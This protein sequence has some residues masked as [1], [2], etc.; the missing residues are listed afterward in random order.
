MRYRALIF[1]F[2]GDAIGLF[3][4]CKQGLKKDGLIIVKE[5]I[6]SKE[7]EFVVDKVCLH[8]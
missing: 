2:T 6:C 3:N 8:I 1:S 5:N 4:R 7:S